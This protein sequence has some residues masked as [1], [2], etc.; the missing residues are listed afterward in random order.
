MNATTEILRGVLAWG[1]Y[2][3][4]SVF[5]H[6]ALKHAAGTGGSYDLGRSF[7]ALV[8]GWGLAAVAAWMISAWAWTL[9][10]TRHSLIEANAVSAL[11][12]ALCAAAAALWLGERF[13][14][15]EAAG[16]L[17]VAAGVWLLQG[18]QYSL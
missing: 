12:V 7:T 3:A 8:S 5:G 16:T 11:R 10:L 6:V 13:G 4:G 18:K 9:A 1:M 14:P 17:L 2:F 15:R